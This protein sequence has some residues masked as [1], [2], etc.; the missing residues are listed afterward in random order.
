MM[1]HYGIL[2]YPAR[3]SLSPVMHN[4]AFKAL[5]IDAQYGVFEIV[6]KDLQDFM[7]KV[8][9]EPISGLS[10]SLPY[11]EFILNF[12]NESSEDVKKIGAANTIINRGGFL[13]AHNTDFIGSNKA[14]LEAGDLSGKKVVV[15]GAGG[16]ARAIIYGLIQEGAQVSVMNRTKEKADE[17]AA[18]FGIESVNFD[19]SSI[20]DILIHTTSIWT[21]NEHLGGELPFFCQ[22]D[23]LK[24]FELVMDIAYNPQITPLLSV[25]S[26]IGIKYL[27]GDKMLLYQAVAQFELWTE[28]KAPL[29]IMEKALIEALS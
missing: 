17:I 1:K 5:G 14:L 2:A 21:K 15:I 3:H 22:E 9:H 29:E 18:D 26:K 23:Y 19:Q 20:G 10:V 12:V 11:K 7:E 25:A 4:A 8:K 24:N 27:S 13:Y 16:S 6:E 28:E